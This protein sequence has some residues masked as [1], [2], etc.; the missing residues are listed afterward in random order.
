MIHEVS[1]MKCKKKKRAPKGAEKLVRV[2]SVI[3]IILTVILVL[4]VGFLIVSEISNK[5]DQV[6]NTEGTIVG[7]PWEKP[8]A[9]KPADYTWEE[10]LNLSGEEQL[11]FPNANGHYGRI[12]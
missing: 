11:A 7:M 2:L 8:G 12:K 4:M 9:K 6:T 10:F 5:A 1:A 3:A